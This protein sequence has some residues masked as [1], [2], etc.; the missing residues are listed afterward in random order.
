MKVGNKYGEFA[1]VLFVI[2][3]I[4]LLTSADSCASDE[5][6]NDPI[7]VLKERF[8]FDNGKI[9]DYRKGKAI[10]RQIKT[11]NEAELIIGSGIYLNVSPEFLIENSR[12][13]IQANQTSAVSQI[14]LFSI[15]P[16]KEDLDALTVDESDLEAIE[17]CKMRDCDMKLSAD[18]IELFSSKMNREDMLY[19]ASA[20]LAIHKMLLDYAEAYQRLGPQSMITYRDQDYP[21]DAY[22]EYLDILTS[23][24]L[25]DDYSPDII[26]Y[27]QEF[28]NYKYD[29][30]E[31][32]FFW[33]KQH[34]EGLRPIIM[35]N[36]TCL[37]MPDSLRPAI[38]TKTLIYS[39]HYYEG[40]LEVS[41]IIPDSKDRKKPGCHLLF[42]KR[43]RFD[44]LRKG[45][46]LGIKKSKLRSGVEEE[47]KNYLEK[48]KDKV[49]RLYAERR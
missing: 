24:Q 11:S 6:L 39:S 10:T 33:I 15:P 29:Q 47:V 46:F 34:F 26:K 37:F 1:G 9:K 23:A 3:L 40:S 16:V 43:A 14:G 13:I 31:D 18:L 35:L 41:I 4:V 38:L 12:D 30:A 22:R 27:L 32:Y 17:N 21:L 36:H 19:R 28:P 42:L 48:T 25:L 8:K 20:A 7:Y 45:D 5:R 44:T 2:P 49:E